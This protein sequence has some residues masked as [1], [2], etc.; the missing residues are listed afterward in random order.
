RDYE[1]SL[2][3]KS[4]VV[5]VDVDDDGRSERWFVGIDDGN[6]K[7]SKRNQA[8]DSTI[9]VHKQL[10]ERIVTGEANAVAALLRGAMALEGDSK[11]P[12]IRQ[13]AV[14]D[15]FDEE[16]TILNHDE[17]P[18]DLRVRVEAASDF[19]DLFEV[20]DALSKK[21]E[22]STRIDDGNLVLGY[23]RETFA[24]STTIS[25]SA[26]AELDAEGLSFDVHLE[27]QGEWTTKLQV[28]VGGLGGAATRRGRTSKARDLERW[29]DD[30]PKL[31]CDWQP[32]KHIYRRSL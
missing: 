32:L 31:E 16:L 23:D 24:R 15:G 7:V 12:V 22:Y 2:A 9:R 18:V 17:E 30:A 8:A 26:P 14:G 10:L 27:P 1:P 19:A 3:H 29:L 11:L 25:S 6:I 13:R 28:T 21:G 4:G 20:K 5:R